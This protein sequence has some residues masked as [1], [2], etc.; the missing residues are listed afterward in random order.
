M[1]RHAIIGCGRVAANHVDGFG[2]VDGWQV[3]T[4]CDR[5]D[6]VHA[7]A[8]AHGIPRATQDVGEVLADAAVTSVSVAV[9]HAT[10][11]TIVEA[12]LGAGKH[13]LVE[14]PFG[15]DPAR[16]RQLAGL[17]A[18]QGLTLSVVS[19]HR[20]DPV[21][22]AV[23][24][25]LARGLL[26]EVV[27]VTASLQAHREPEYYTGSYWRGTLRG[28]GG[29]ALVNQGYH[30]LDTVRWLV[31]DLTV[32]SASWRTVA[33]GDVIETEDTISALLATTGGAPVTLSV[34]V[35]SPTQWCTRIEVVGTAGSVAFDIDHPGRLLRWE[36][37]PALDAE[38][39]AESRR[40]LDAD[41]PGPAY[42]GVSH[43]RQI[44]DFCDAVATGRSMLFTPTESLGTLETITALYA[45][46]GG[47]R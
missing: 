46:A 47:A 27:C 21:V 13:V 14:K 11:A 9:D 44:A 24:D 6:D 35:A 33:L 38:A 32:R 22:L 37:P 28:E 23:R 36:G 45:H 16:A 30:C 20:Y 1:T 43:R 3:T 8:R 2:R 26:G 4:A 41:P 10:H 39:T 40:S 7:F 5:T 25:W 31:G 17:A 12:A 42:Y 15:L 18:A 34:T 19:Q 29:S